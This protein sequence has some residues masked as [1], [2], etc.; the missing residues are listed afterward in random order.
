MNA[1][2]LLNIEDVIQGHNE[3]EAIGKDFIYEYH[4]ETLA[5]ISGARGPWK[6]TSVFMPTFS[7]LFFS[8][9]I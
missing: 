4:C 7:R 9:I 6:I 3:L 8:I 1:S 2:I 5:P